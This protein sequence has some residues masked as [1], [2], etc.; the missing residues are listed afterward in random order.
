MQIE[1][2]WGKVKAEASEIKGVILGGR[3][4]EESSKWK[5]QIEE[6]QRNVSLL[7]EDLDESR[8]RWQKN[9]GA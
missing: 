6:N 2:E 3:E 5:Q 1:R 8:V 7:Y 9:F 4:E